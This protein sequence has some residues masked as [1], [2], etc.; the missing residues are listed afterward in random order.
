M[1]KITDIIFLVVLL[2]GLLIAFPEY[3]N[4]ILE[5]KIYTLFTGLGLFMIIFFIWLRTQSN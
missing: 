1:G 5:N 4:K 2:V 3:I